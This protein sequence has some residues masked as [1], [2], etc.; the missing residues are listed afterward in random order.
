MSPLENPLPL[1]RTEVQIP[2]LGIGTW[3]WGDRLFWGYGRTHTDADLEE[4]FHAALA[5]G[6]AFFDT[7][8][9][10]G[11]GRSERLLGRFL[12][13]LPAEAPRP[14]LA[15]K[16][17]P[18]PW[19]W[20]P[21][22]LARALQGS[23]R[24]LGLA[25][26]D[27]YQIHWPYPPRSIDVWVQA[28]GQAVR[29][30]LARAA[31]V[32]NYNLSQ[33]KRAQAILADLDVP[34]ASNQVEFSLLHRK[35]EYD[36]LLAYCREQ[37][38][39]LIAYSPLAMGLLTGKYTPDNPPPGV[40]GRRFSREYLA[41]LQPLLGLMREIGQ[42]HG[43]KTPAQVALNWVIAKGAVPIP[44]A[45]NAVQV[46][47]NAGALGWRLTDEEIAALDEASAAVQRPSRG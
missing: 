22:A 1:G 25:Q 19:R 33:T 16:F 40:R 5:Q 24:R 31:G 21:R 12:A 15:T 32:S 39:T 17:F 10:Y 27:L 2:P 13:Q 26:V 7:A 11:T 6:V 18:Y 20:R 35:P 44:G 28:L 3:A 42:G 38:I 41:R 29:A 36:G 23:L 14:V 43:N 30:G 8:E 9:I 47:A 4:A 37:G 45:K 46:E 34:L